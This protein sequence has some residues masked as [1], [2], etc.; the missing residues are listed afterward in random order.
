MTVPISAAPV[1]SRNSNDIFY[2]LENMD[3]LLSHDYMFET[4]TYT[5]YTFN[6]VRID[7]LSNRLVPL[8][9]SSTNPVPISAD[10]YTD[11]NNIPKYGFTGISVPIDNVDP[12]TNKFNISVINSTNV[13]NY[14]VNQYAADFKVLLK[15]LIYNNPNFKSMAILENPHDPDGYIHS[16]ESFL[17]KVVHKLSAL[18]GTFFLIE[19]ILKLYSK[20]LNQELISF[21]EDPI[22][23]FIYRV[24]STLPVELW[25]DSIKKLVHPMSWFDNYNIVNSKISDLVIQPFDLKKKISATYKLRCISYIDSER[26]FINRSPYDI[27]P[28]VPDSAKYYNYNGYEIDYISPPNITPYFPPNNDPVSGSNYFNNIRYISNLNNNSYIE[29]KYLSSKKRNYDA[30]GR[31]ATPLDDIFNFNY[32]KNNTK[33]GKDI[34]INTIATTAIQSDYDKI[35]S[36]INDLIYFN[37]KDI[38]FDYK[39]N[40]S[41]NN[42][43]IN[44]TYKKP[45][46]VLQYKWDVYIENKLIKS[47]LTFFNKYSLDL[48]TL[49]N[50]LG[51]NKH[52][53]FNPITNKNELSEY[54][55]YS[56]TDKYNSYEFLKNIKIE[57]TLIYNKFRKKIYKYDLSSLIIRKDLPISTE[58]KLWNRNY[59]GTRMK[60]I[61][62]LSLPVSGFTIPNMNYQNMSLESFTSEAKNNT[63]SYLSYNNNGI[64]T[65]SFEYDVD[66]I[67]SL[68]IPDITNFIQSNIG[69][70][71]KVSFRPKLQD[72]NEVIFSVITKYKWILKYGD[73][74]NNQPIN[75]I[76]TIETSLNYVNL[77]L[78][79]TTNQVGDITIP[80]SNYK[81][82]LWITLNNTKMYQV[83]TSTFTFQNL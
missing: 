82:E 41:T 28:V 44:I 43:L 78:M 67:N 51:H 9:A 12:L 22:D 7:I 45:G 17:L 83:D 37:P 72:T 73:V 6:P 64:A 33:F 53:V 79:N 69:I 71:Y 8:Y 32:K 21:M 54:N 39:L 48:K 16:C 50:L 42:P 14:Y 35:S 77:S 29:T 68:I 10:N 57:L 34:A 52:Y 20:F 40:L 23:P 36:P 47:D 19:L 49:S 70:N 15:D 13:K 75:P 4:G 56:S 76:Y 46:L 59:L 63:I 11:V 2:Q 24:T 18:K 1:S 66:F 65:N 74:L 26:Y 80:T 60:N 81:L 27:L 25:R 61:L 31:I 5:D 30:Y 58:E 38:S 55:S 3:K 62:M